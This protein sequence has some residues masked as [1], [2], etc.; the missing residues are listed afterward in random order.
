MEQFKPNP[1]RQQTLSDEVADQL[2]DAIRDGSIP[3][4]T[5][6]VELELAHQF[7][8][9]RVPIREAIQSLVD[10]GLVKKTPRHGAYV[11]L[12]SLEEIDEISSLRV[13]LERFVI[14]R[15]VAQWQP[16]HQTQ[17][18]QIV[19]EM[20]SAAET[21]DYVHMYKLDYDYHYLLWKIADHSIVLEILAGLRAR[22]NRF[23]YEAV[24]HLAP[25]EVAN[26]LDSHDFLLQLIAS[27]DVENAQREITRHVL[28]AKSR[29]LQ[30]CNFPPTSACEQ[31]D[32]PDT[33]TSARA[34]NSD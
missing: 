15:V 10:Q 18:H 4:G 22:I 34:S 23:L 9:S 19:T 28:G 24:T 16:A 14:E 13:V 5:R 30:H 29:I 12:P 2:R 27:G 3:P 33:D 8:V 17:L 7:G 26:H 25:K 20:R 1:V 31:D 21:G 32:P 6:L 11:Y